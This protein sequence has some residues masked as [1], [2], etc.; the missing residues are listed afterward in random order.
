MTPITIRT[1]QSSD[2]TE[3]S[4]LI[5]KNA[6][7]TLKPHY[8]DAQWNVFLK[9]YEIAEVTKKIAT[10]KVFCATQEND[11]VGTVALKDDLVVGFYTRVQNL[12]QGIG[13]LLMQHLEDYAKANGLKTIQLTASPIGLA[14]YYKNGWQK[15]RAYVFEYLG[16]GFD[17]TLMVKTIAGK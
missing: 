12:N 14:F 16:V 15:V 5:I 4:E 6:E 7:V 1:A 11:I 2:A 17:E 13:K 8:S 3:L 10:Q 9:Y